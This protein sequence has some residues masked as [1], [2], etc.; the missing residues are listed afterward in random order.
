M[1]ARPA[2]AAFVFQSTLP[3]G[4]RRAASFCP[5][6]EVEFQSTLPRGERH[7]PYSPFSGQIWFQSTLPRGERQAHA[8]RRVARLDVSI[9]APARGAT[10]VPALIGQDGVVSIHAPA[11]GATRQPHG[12]RHALRGFNPRSRAGSDGGRVARGE[13]AGA[14][15]STL[16]RGERPKLI[17][18][19]NDYLA[20]SIHAPAR[21]ATITMKLSAASIVVSIHAPARGATVPLSPSLWSVSKFQSTLPRGERQH[22]GSL[23]SPLKRVSIHA[24]ARGATRAAERGFRL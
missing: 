14:F 5:K 18:F 24:P 12:G 17:D 8:Y 7:E 13:R 15:Q 23:I 10:V 6:C 2:S 4:E 9:H 11:R 22:P 20:V 3:R 1:R 21:G 16:P 19:Y